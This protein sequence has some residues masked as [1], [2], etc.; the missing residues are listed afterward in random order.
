MVQLKTVLNKYLGK[1]VFD[2]H[3]VIRCNTGLYTVTCM[4]LG[5]WGRIDVGGPH[6]PARFFVNQ[7]K[8]RDDEYG[9]KFNLGGTVYARIF[10]APRKGT[11]K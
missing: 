8:H 11:S 3:L 1:S 7:H 10:R 6:L 2:Y 4:G 9:K 5:W